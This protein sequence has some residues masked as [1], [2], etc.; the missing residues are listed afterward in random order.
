M[1][2]CRFT[3]VQELVELGSVTGGVNGATLAA[4]RPRFDGLVL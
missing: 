4:G 2:L 3:W 1:E